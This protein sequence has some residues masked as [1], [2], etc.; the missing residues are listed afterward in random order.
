[1]AALRPALQVGHHLTLH[2]KVRW[3]EHESIERGEHQRG[4]GL[5]ATTD[6][7]AR[8]AW[9]GRLE[10]E[11]PVPVIRLVE[12]GSWVA[13]REAERVSNLEHGELRVPRAMELARR[14]HPEFVTGLP[15]LELGVNALC[16]RHFA[17]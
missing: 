11:C 10:H 13:R 5:A 3:L 9:I 17:A 12:S 8:S 6:Q 4:G 1:M 15:A 16:I 14:I 2:R 7:H